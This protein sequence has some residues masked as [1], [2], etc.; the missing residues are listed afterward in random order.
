MKALIIGA[1]GATGKDLV[2]HLLND[3]TFTEIHI[4]ARRETGLQHP[5]LTTHIIDFDKP[6][7]WQHLL[8]GDVAFSCLGTTLKAAGSKT[9]QWK[10]DHDYQYNF[11]KAAKSNGVERYVLVS[12]VGAKPGSG[13]YYLKMKGQLEEKV[14]ALQFKT[15][16]LFQPGPLE[17]EKSDRLGERIS[18]S[19]IKFLNRLGLLGKQRPLPTQILAQAMIN[20]VK[21]ITIGLHHLKTPEIFNLAGK[22]VQS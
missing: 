19:I 3:S 15:T 10:V 1:T 8:S 9:A 14:A 20:S 17:R 4:F 13:I 21:S 12:S 7:Q 18:I 11:A 16:I 6:E 2:Q 5:K 22:E